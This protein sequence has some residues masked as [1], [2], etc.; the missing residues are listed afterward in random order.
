[1]EAERETLVSESRLLATEL[2]TLKQ[3]ANLI[4]VNL[5]HSSGKSVKLKGKNKC[6]KCKNKCWVFN[7]CK[8]IE[9]RYANKS[10]TIYKGTSHVL[11]LDFSFKIKTYL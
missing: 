8:F 3:H 11:M 9:L 2:R 6:N 5:E 1:M 10:C 7:K 4:Y